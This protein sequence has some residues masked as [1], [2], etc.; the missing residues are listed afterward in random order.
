MNHTRGGARAPRGDPGEISPPAS[1]NAASAKPNDNFVKIWTLPPFSAGLS[2]S[3]DQPP[4]GCL[5]GRSDDLQG[6]DFDFRVFSQA[7]SARAKMTTELT[8]SH[9]GKGVGFSVMASDDLLSTGERDFS[10]RS[11][12]V[13]FLD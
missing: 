2:S 11:R 4:A 8:M 1:T 5:A 12:E 9:H 6:V 3:R 10:G 7:T 13:S